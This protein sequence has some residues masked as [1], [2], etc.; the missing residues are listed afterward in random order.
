MKTKYYQDSTRYQKK[1]WV[2]YGDERWRLLDVAEWLQYGISYP[3]VLYIRKKK[4]AEECL[5]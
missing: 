2:R 4:E 5:K 3:G 1:Q